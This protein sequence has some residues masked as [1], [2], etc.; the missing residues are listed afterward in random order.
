[1]RHH[2][3]GLGTNDLFKLLH[4]DRSTTEL[5]EVAHNLVE[6][7][8]DSHKVSPDGL[9]SN[10]LPGSLSKFKSSQ[11]SVGNHRCFADGPRASKFDPEDPA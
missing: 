4:E 11:S 7:A 6:R 9:S 10:W 2:Q 3:I 5:H 8:F 1:M